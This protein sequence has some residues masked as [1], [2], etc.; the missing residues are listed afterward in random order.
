MHGLLHLSGADRPYAAD[1]EGLY[2]GEL[3]RIKDESARSCGV[4]EGLKVIV[5]VARRMEGDDDWRLN[6]RVEKW[7]ETKPA[8][9]FEQGR[10]AWGA[11]LGPDE[12][13]WEAGLA[14]SVRLDKSGFLGRDALIAKKDQPLRKRLIQVV[15]KDAAVY[16]WGG[17][18]ISITAT[19]GEQTVGELTSVGWSPLAGACVGLGYLRGVVAQERHRGTR[20]HVH[21][22][23]EPTP[24]ALYDH[25]PYR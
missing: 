20:A 24:V 21:L 17:E 4:V 5:P 10:R 19:N 22:W 15:F 13:P 12:T 25:W 6:R 18:P 23:G 8:H 1:S 2:L 3:S 14:S 16:A 7:L 9:T 11:E